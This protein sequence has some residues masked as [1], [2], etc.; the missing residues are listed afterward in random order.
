MDAVYLHS[1]TRCFRVSKTERYCF[2][3]L[4]FEITCHSPGHEDTTVIRAEDV[5]DEHPIIVLNFV[6]TTER[7]Q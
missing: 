2:S 1:K 7:V 6:Q 5:V 3:R 4:C